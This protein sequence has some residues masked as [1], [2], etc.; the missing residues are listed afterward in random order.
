ME[1]RIQVLAASRPWAMT[2]SV[3]LGAPASNAGH[4][5]SVPPASTIEMATSSLSSRRPATTS[6]KVDDS[7]SS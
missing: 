6:S 7:P 5:A 1:S 4:E 2:S 3:T